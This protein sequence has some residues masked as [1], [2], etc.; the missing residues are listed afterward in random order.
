MNREKE[1]NRHFQSDTVT[2]TE[3]RTTASG[4]TLKAYEHAKQ[5]L[6]AWLEGR[7]PTDAVLAEYIRYLNAEGKSAA[8]INLVVAAVKWMA[9]HQGADYDVGPLTVATHSK[10]R[11]A[12]KKGRR[13]QADGLTWE[14]VERMCAAAASS[15]TT[16]GLRDAAM[17]SLMSDCLLRISEAVAVNVEDV[18]PDGLLIG[19]EEEVQADDAL[20]ICDST[21]HRIER[22]RKSAGIRSGA[23]FRRIRYHKH[24]T[25]DRLGVKG[26]REAIQRWAKA[27]G[28][29]GAISGQSLRI[30]SALSLAEA[31]ASVKE[32]QRAGRWLDPA[33]PARYVREAPGEYNPMEKYKAGK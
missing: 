22:Y 33:M 32:M 16:S 21:R 31:G 9:A 30:G 25:A 29:K 23:L 14:D 28:I 8:T 20:Y 2:R 4:N 10:I 19:R 13:R 1:S 18:A 3:A 15:D 26:A 12:G 11:M 17:I 6:D 24:V 7:Q 27:A 5:K